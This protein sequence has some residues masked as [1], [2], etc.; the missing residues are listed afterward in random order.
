MR[1]KKLHL[2]LLRA[3]LTPLAGTFAVTVFVLVLVLLSNQR[4]K[5][6]GKGLPASVFFEIMGYA[7]LTFVHL[8]LVLAVLMAAL[9]TLGK[10]G[11]DYE[12]AA[13]KASGISLQRILRPLVG[14]TLV[15]IAVSF[16][17]AGYVVP[18]A[19]LKM[20][21]RIYDADRSRPEFALRPGVF[22]DLIPGYVMRVAG[23][24]EATGTLYDMR[25]YDHTRSE[26]LCNIVISADSARMTTLDS[27]LYLQLELY[28]GVRYEEDL[29]APRTAL[30]VQQ[31]RPFTRIAFDTL[32]YNIDMSAF[33]P[34]QTDEEDFRGNYQVRSF[35]RLLTDLDSLYE[36]PRTTL[37]RIKTQ[38]EALFRFQHRFSPAAP[39]APSP[40][41]T[42]SPQEHERFLQAAMT[43]LRSLKVFIS[44]QA[45]QAASQAE[46]ARK[47]N[48]SLQEKLA[49]PLCLL[50]FVFVGGPLGA[51]VRKGG[52]GWPTVLGIGFFVVFWLL[53][54][55]GKKLAIEGILPVG[56]GVWLPLMVMAPFALFVTVQ[57]AT[58]SRLFDL[59]V[60]RATLRRWVALPRTSA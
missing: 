9:M 46:L 2:L 47:F 19:N 44:G 43:N 4:A 15:L 48:I 28:H 45:Q 26:Y 51:V 10:L 1:F 18:W 32:V 38:E 54:T 13:L 21:R 57:S 30:A 17:F 22:N 41:D 8:A 11:E 59:S 14:F 35:S 55:Y 7:S 5:L 50:V 12:L 6:M 60:W 20:Y 52:L 49:V 16:L 58:D 3:F 39:L 53:Y 27:L 24:N 37:G 25:I 33:L 56:V 42:L 29:T 40:F 31:G 36:R 23:R 34:S